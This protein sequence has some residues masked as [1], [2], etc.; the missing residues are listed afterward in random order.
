MLRFNENK[1]SIY[2]SIIIYADLV[3]GDI[4]HEME[5]EILKYGGFHSYHEAYGALKKEVEELWNEIKSKEYNPDK[6]Y[7]EAIQVTAMARKLALCAA[8]DISE[9]LC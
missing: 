4:R 5:D 6:I 7:K 8:Y 1:F 3:D 9:E 2:K